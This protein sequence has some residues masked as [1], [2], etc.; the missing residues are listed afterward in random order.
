MQSQNNHAAIG[1]SKS[2]NNIEFDL[3]LFLT[4]S[5]LP[6]E[7]TPIIMGFKIYTGGRWWKM[8]VQGLQV[9]IK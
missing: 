5:L 9:P 7:A 2:P 8:A 4:A 1:P 3:L 6:Q